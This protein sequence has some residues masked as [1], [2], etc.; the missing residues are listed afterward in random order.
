MSVEVEEFLSHYGVKGMKWG[1]RNEVGPD[2]LVSRNKPSGEK[3]SR[4]EHKADKQMFTRAVKDPVGFATDMGYEALDR[5]IREEFGRLHTK[6]FEKKGLHADDWH[7]DRSAKQQAAFSKATDSFMKDFTKLMIDDL[8]SNSTTQN[9][10]RVKYSADIVAIKEEPSMSPYEF[11]ENYLYALRVDQLKHADDGVFMYIRPT[12]DAKGNLTG[13]EAVDRT[14]NHQILDDFLAHYGVKGMR[15]GVRRP[16]GPDGLVGKRLGPRPKDRRAISTRIGEHTIDPRMGKEFPKLPGYTS[17]RGGRVAGIV[18]TEWVT[19]RRMSRTHRGVKSDLKARLKEPSRELREKFGE[20]ETEEQRAAF[21]KEAE[22]IL[23]KE[24]EKMTQE[25]WG[26]PR[27][28]SWGRYEGASVYNPDLGQ[29]QVALKRIYTN[30][31]TG[32]TKSVPVSAED[33]LHI[34]DVA[35]INNQMYAIQA[36]RGNPFAL[37]ILANRMVRHANIDEDIILQYSVTPESG[38]SDIQVYMPKSLTD[39]VPG[40]SEAAQHSDISDRAVDDFLAHYGVKGMKWG[41][42]RPV[43][44]DGLV[45]SGKALGRAAVTT[46]KAAAKAGKATGRVT[47]KLTRKLRETAKDRKVKKRAKEIKAGKGAAVNVKDMEDAELK[48]VI[49][50]LNL[51]RQYKQLTAKPAEQPKKPKFDGAMG[52]FI[53]DVAGKQARRH[54]NNYLNAL[55]DPKIAAIAKKAMEENEKQSKK[56]KDEDE[57]DD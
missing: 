26:N 10:Q 41:V 23:R 1:I 34:N 18:D 49:D 39:L 35:G 29:T 51:E 16:V 32:K 2:G 36:A 45:N 52:K 50:R 24:V 19:K 11:G 55:V 40:F 20:I 54:T 4:K 12:F 25:A 9:N 13:V 3:L 5:V 47:V 56:K 38:F 14:L 31:K 30:E 44:P 22:K 15:W 7:E 43:G 21:R 33:Q 42:R 37:V 53:K 17:E 48:A 8:N 46:G 28:S 57:D 27:T 6:H